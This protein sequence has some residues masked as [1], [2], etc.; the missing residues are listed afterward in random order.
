MASTTPKSHKIAFIPGDGIG[1]EIS[2][3]TLRVL[4][5]LSSTHPNT[6]S[7]TPTIL[8]SW[9]SENYLLEGWE[10]VLRMPLPS[11]AGK[12]EGLFVWRRKGGEEG[13]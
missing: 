11:F 13:V 3:A 8:S 7:F 1:T 12:D 9:S 2:D 10:L 4:N 6:F 5:T